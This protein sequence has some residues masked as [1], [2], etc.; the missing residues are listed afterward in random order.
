[1]Q[2]ASRPMDLVI[3]PVAS[4]DYPVA[5]N[6]VFRTLTAEDR[7][8]QTRYFQTLAAESP[9]VGEGLIG[10][11]RGDR[12]VGAVFANILPGQVAQV[13]RPQCEIAEPIAIS[14]SLMEALNVWL[15]ERGPLT[16]QIIDVSF[17]QNDKLV[18]A[19]A[20]YVPLTDLLYL[21]CTKEEFPA[22]EPPL[23]L[24][25]E[26]YSASNHDRLAALLTKT[27]VD[28]LDCPQLD[29]SRPVEDVLTG[30]KAS[31]VF[32]PDLW[33]LFTGSGQDVGCLLLTDHPDFGNVELIYVGLIPS[34]RRIGHGKQI[35]RFAQ[36]KAGC[37][38][39][40][41][42]VVAVD[43][44]NLPAIQAYDQNQMKVW[45]QR[46]VFYRLFPPFTK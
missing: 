8:E 42:L 6:F 13:Y 27:Y 3:R 15:A 18:L 4:T 14:H 2:E 32:S 12:L 20:G 40:E 17:A 26:T 33:F 34:F 11:Y 21:A 35:V 7:A 23:P 36:W 37:L 1:M 39:R 5:W 38:G 29:G 31:G 10:A 41:R 25:V 24:G 16:A 46:S 44:G 45:G 22:E 19:E 9:L 43:G 30:Y 28:S